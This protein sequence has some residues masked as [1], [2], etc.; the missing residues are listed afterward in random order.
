MGWETALDKLIEPLRPQDL[1][2]LSAALIPYSVD[3]DV[4]WSGAKHYF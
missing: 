4:G 1:I 3:R 2:R